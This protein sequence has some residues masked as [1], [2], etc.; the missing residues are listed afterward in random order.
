MQRKSAISQRFALWNHSIN[1]ERTS[2]GENYQERDELHPYIRVIMLEMANYVEQSITVGG[3]EDSYVLPVKD[4]LSVLW[5][6]EEH[7]NCE[8]TLLPI[9]DLP[10]R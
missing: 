10:R 3:D 9:K 2:T 1:V 7:P 4:L 8:V 6:R 5:K